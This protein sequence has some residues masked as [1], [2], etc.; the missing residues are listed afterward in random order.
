MSGPYDD[1]IHLPRPIS[2]THPPMS[3]RDR[4]AQFSPFAALSG[5]EA[6]LAETARLTEQRPELGEDSREALDRRLQLLADWLPEPVTVTVTYFQPDR[7]KV[8]G[9][10]VSVTG[11]LLRF[12]RLRQCLLLADRREI[13]LADLL[14]I[15]SPL[16]SEDL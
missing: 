3:M 7:Q 16:L 10:C 1:I 15:E 2:R 8:G 4:A 6:A 12:D 13:P 9:R 11:Q 5:H 14:D